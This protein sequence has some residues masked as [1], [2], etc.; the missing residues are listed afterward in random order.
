MNILKDETLPARGGGAWILKKGQR[1][2]VIDMEGEQIGDFVAFNAANLRERFNQARTRSNS[3]KFLISTGDHLYSK[4]NNVML[5]IVEDTYGIHDLQYGMCSE[6]VY[7]RERHSYAEGFVVGG[8]LGRPTVGCWEILTEALK[9]WDIPPEDIPD[10]LNLFQTVDFDIRS[11]TFALAEG[12][13][14]PGDHVVL[15]AQMDVLCALS[16]C[17]ATGHPLRVQIF[18]A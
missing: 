14:Q 7:K 8:S 1:I 10:P 15:V 6:F 11:G 12:R 18:S 3:G 16:A 4:S 17:P 2:R 5:T 13:S 9:P